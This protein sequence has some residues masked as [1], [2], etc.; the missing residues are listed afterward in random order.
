VNIEAAFSL[1]TQ[2]RTYHLFAE[3]PAEAEA[4]KT[5]LQQMAVLMVPPEVGHDKPPFWG[6]T[7]R[8]GR[9]LLLKCR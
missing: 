9:P 4:W 1:V 7:G 3:T 2:H 8:G 6:Q 5:V